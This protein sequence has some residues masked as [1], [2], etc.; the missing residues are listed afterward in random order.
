[1]VENRCSCTNGGL[2]SISVG[3]ESV[4]IDTYRVLDSCRDKDC[5]ENVKVYLTDFGQEIINHTDNIRAKWTNILVH[6]FVLFLC[7]T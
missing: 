6:K 1:M 7:K 3:K 5:F 2:P 4:C